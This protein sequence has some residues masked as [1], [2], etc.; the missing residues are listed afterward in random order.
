MDPF[1]AAILIGFGGAALKSLFGFNEAEARNRALRERELENKVAANDQEI[2]RQRSI[3]KVLSAQVA[4]SAASGIAPTS[5]SFKAIQIDTINK[6]AED[7]EM[8]GLQLDVE[9]ENLEQ[10]QRNNNNEAL[11]KTFGNLFAGAEFAARIPDID[12]DAGKF[13]VFGPSSTLSGSFT[14]KTT[15]NFPSSGV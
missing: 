7:Q 3:K 2:Q 1:S 8:T 6:F 9:N 15:S 11:I 12:E 13:Q 5:G 10:Q 14:E 4:Q